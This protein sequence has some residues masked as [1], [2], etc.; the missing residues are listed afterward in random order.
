LTP[1]LPSVI[2]SGQI[3]S[4]VVMALSASLGSLAAF[5][6]IHGP[7]TLAPDDFF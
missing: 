3:D 1:G 4:S 5:D 7:K 2:R 6:Q